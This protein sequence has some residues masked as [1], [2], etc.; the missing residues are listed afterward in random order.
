MSNPPKRRLGTGVD[1]LLSSPPPQADGRDDSELQEIPLDRLQPSPYQPRTRFDDQA[2]Q[3]LA[4]SLKERGAIQPV[5]VRR[6]G[7]QY[8]L[9]AGERRLRAARAAG[10][11]SLPAIVRDL[12]DDE[13][14]TIT[15]IENIQREDLN[16]IDEAQA[17]R[18]LAERLGQTHEQIAER[19]GR[20]RATV[21]NLIRLLELNPD[22]QK[23]V[24]D[25]KLSMGH[26]RVLVP[27]P[28]KRQ[29]E[30]ARAIQREDLSVRETE[31]RASEKKTG[32][33]HTRT[34]RSRPGRGA[35]AEAAVGSPGLPGRVPPREEGGQ[36]GAALQQRRFPAGSARTARLLGRL[37][38]QA[39][40]QFRDRGEAVALQVVAD[41]LVDRAAGQ[42][43]VEQHGADPHRGGAGDQKLQRVRR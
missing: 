32:S 17:L 28:A 31:R 13:A 25:G 7:E 2:I 21:T 22:V 5:V 40:G 33:S 18:G 15:L 9:V 8:E 29:K 4:D 19:V 43:I 11:E 3:S 30:L 38:A 36:P 35:L 6:V 20:A 37:N 12:S 42:R 24:R 23:L 14:A 26:A 1:A 34:S 27:L 16:P 39:A 41:A 10:L